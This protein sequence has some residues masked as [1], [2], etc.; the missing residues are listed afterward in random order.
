MSASEF[1]CLEKS[2]VIKKTCSLEPRYKSECI[3]TYPD[4]IESILCYCV[5]DF[6]NS[7]AELD[8]IGFTHSKHQ[9]TAISSSASASA[10][11]G[12][13]I[14]V[15]HNNDRNKRTNLS[16]SQTFGVS[17]N[18]LVMLIFMCLFITGSFSLLIFNT[19]CVHLC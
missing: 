14:L 8:K 18:Y 9:E 2:K 5:Y 10:S 3:V 7:D 15:N 13:P 1:L 19:V 17:T 4:G 6:C 11:A 12:V 16:A